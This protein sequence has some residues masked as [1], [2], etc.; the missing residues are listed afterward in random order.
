MHPIRSPLAQ[1]A[2]VALLGTLALAGCKKKEADTSMTP[3]ASTTIATPPPAAPA[4]VGLARPDGLGRGRDRRRARNAA[5]PDMKIAAPTTTFSTKDKIIAAVSTSTTDAMA[6]V[7]GKLAAKWTHQD[8]N[9][10]VNEEERP[11]QFHGAQ[12]Y[13]FQ[14]ENK[15]PWPAGKYKVEVMLDGNMVQ[16][17]EFEVK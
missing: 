4:T 12:V 8:S 13:D 15:Q 2:L 17:R 6:T 11:I 9:Q 14:I 1:A 5:G 3:P 7:P 16:A 10:V